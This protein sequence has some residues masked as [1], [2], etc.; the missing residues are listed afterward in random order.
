MIDTLMIG[1][2]N[3]ALISEVSEYQGIIGGIV[4]ILLSCPFLTN[5]KPLMQ[6]NY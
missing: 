3:L 6:G 4:D 1:A 5:L 2:E